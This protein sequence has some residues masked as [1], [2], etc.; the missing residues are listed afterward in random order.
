MR[1]ADL[2]QHSAPVIGDEEVEAVSR[3]LYSGRIAQGPEVEAFEEECA[4]LVG[5]RHAVAVS[6]GRK[7]MS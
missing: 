2:I 5:R 1:T 7:P 4:A 6:S 3:V